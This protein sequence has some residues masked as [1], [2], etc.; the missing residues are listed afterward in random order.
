MKEAARLKADPDPVQQALGRYQERIMN[1]MAT[2]YLP[3]REGEK[4]VLFRVT[5]GGGQADAFTMTAV[6]GFLLALLLP[7]VQAARE[8]ARRTT[9]MNN[10]RQIMLAMHNYH[11]AKKSFPSHANYGADGK[12]LLSWRVH[13]LPYLE[14]KALYDQFHLDEPWDSEHN[15]GLISQMPAVFVDPSSRW[16]PVDGRTHYLGVKGKGMIFDGTDKG[17]D[18]RAITDGT[19]NTIMVVQV[20]DDR[21]TTW[22]KPDDWELDEQYPLKGLAGSMHPGVFGAGYADGSIRNISESIDPTV[23][24]GLLTRAGGEVVQAP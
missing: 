3:K 22:T 12:P 1:D 14:Q 11:D 19:S 9:S 15:K 7:A 13:I 23:F 6:T 16:Q 24:K 20:N 18:I 5:G 21:A 8:A 2:A 17:T 10:L 4:L